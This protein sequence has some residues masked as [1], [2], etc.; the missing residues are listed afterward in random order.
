MVS[1]LKEGKCREIMREKDSPSGLMLFKGKCKEILREN[2]DIDPKR[3]GCKT[4]T[5]EGN[6]VLGADGAPKETHPS[7]AY[8]ALHRC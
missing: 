6:D 2:P 8:K 3:K 4:V 7:V 5:S 1:I